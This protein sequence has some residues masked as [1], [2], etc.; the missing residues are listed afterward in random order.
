MSVHTVTAAWRLPTA[1]AGLADTERWCAWRHGWIDGRWT[2]VPHS[3]KGG[4]AKSTVPATWARWTAVTVLKDM[5]GPALMLGDG[6]QGVDLDACLTDGVLEP[7]AQE[8]VDRIAAYTEVSPS[9]RGVKLFFYGP[10]GESKEVTFG[11]AVDFGN[12]KTKRREIAYYTWGRYFTVTGNV[13]I[14]RPLRQIDEADA[15]WLRQRIEDQRQ[16]SK[17]P[18]PKKSASRASGRG[19]TDGIP[20]WLTKIVEQGV[21]DGERSDKF[22]NVV[23]WL[24]EAG[25]DAPAITA[26]LEQYPNGIAA[27]YS[28]RLRQEVERCIR[29]KLDS[30]APA[31]AAI[32]DFHAYLPMHQYLYAPTRELWPAA[33]VDGSIA[34]D[35]WPTDSRGARVKPSKW[36]DLNRPVAQLTWHPGEPALIRDRI[37]AEGGWVKHA[38]V[39]VFNYYRPPSRETGDASQAGPWRELL[40]RLY[41]GEAAHIERWF[42]HRVQHPGEKINHAL[43]LGGRQGIGKDS[44]L[45]PIVRAV[46]PWNV[47]EVSPTV[48]MGR[49]N[50]YVKSVILRVSEARDMGDVDR[51]KMYDH[52]KTLTA[53]PPETIMVDEKHIREQRV[54]N[55]C[56]VIYTTNH[57]LDGLYLPPD[58]RRHFVAWSEMN[59]EDYAA[60]YWPGFYAWLAQGGYAHVCA[61]LAQMDLSDFDPKAP[62]PRTEAFYQVVSANQAEGDS[63][64]ADAIDH[65]GNPRPQAL[66]LDMLLGAADA[67][68]LTGLKEGIGDRKNRRALPH[69]LDRAGYLVVKNPD[70]AD[71]QWKIR[72][73]RQN[74][75][76]RREL[77]ERDRHAAVQRVIRVTS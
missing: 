54:F 57:L 5:E 50:G 52:V 43:V 35:G 42:A 75:Y 65:L 25:R 6:L 47:S 41:P 44:L 13:F 11:E 51:Y 36:L 55:L 56:S 27:K 14:D 53:C 28:G 31:D 4:K 19:P 72:G 70:A 15:D 24:Y 34:A 58:D 45:E 9:G 66:T 64:L 32:D 26:F 16:R 74:V 49:F 18:A 59:R 20:A 60:D 8:I 69:R 63:E 7:W 30:V 1:L 77:S 12:G 38:G 40:Q 62:P 48:L 21:P 23:C 68:G 76:A 67:L 39:T 73:R 46:G 3:A 71:G 22:F 17:K 10:E 61:Y 33:S 37:V 29:K 2:K